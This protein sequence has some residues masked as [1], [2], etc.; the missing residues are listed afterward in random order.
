VRVPDLQTLAFIVFFVAV[1]SIGLSRSWRP[2]DRLRRR[3]TTDLRVEAA[4]QP[5]RR[6]DHVEAL[7]TITSL[8]DLGSPEVGV[9]CTEY[10]DE[11]STDSDGHTTR[12]TCNTLAH[13]SWTPV[14]EA[15]G[16]QSVQLTVPVEAPFSYEGD[17]LSFRWEL[18]ARGRRKHRLDAQVRTPLSVLP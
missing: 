18:V 2:L 16:V 8:R 5:V 15:A 10:Y 11:E 7:V 9:V 1:V 3:R 12:I 13:E 4:G 6:G 14:E 17:A